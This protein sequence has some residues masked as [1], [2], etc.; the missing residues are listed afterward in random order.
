MGL[1]CRD[2]E[3]DPDSCSEPLPPVLCCRYISNLVPT[4]GSPK[5]VG[6]HD[7]GS[8]SGKNGDKGWCQDRNILN[9]C[10]CWFSVMKLQSY[11]GFGHNS[12]ISKAGWGI[13]GYAFIGKRVGCLISLSTCDCPAVNLSLWVCHQHPTRLPFSELHLISPAPS[14][15]WLKTYIFNTSVKL[16]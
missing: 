15:F 5:H 10:W 2:Q 1:H 4:F 3:R 13:R 6:Q 16:T 14:G 7:L 12:G 8:V 11:R 9:W